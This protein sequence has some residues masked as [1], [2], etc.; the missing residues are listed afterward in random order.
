MKNMKVLGIITMIFLII[1]GL[2]WGLIGLVQWNFLAS[3][4]GYTS[5]LTRTIYILAGLSAVFKIVCWAKHSK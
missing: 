4:F 3:V 1:G 2:N 5:V